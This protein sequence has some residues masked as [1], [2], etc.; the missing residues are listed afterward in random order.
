MAPSQPSTRN[1]LPSS[2]QSSVARK[3]SP[4][5]AGVTWPSSPN[6]LSPRYRSANAPV[7]VLPLSTGGRVPSITQTCGSMP[8]ITPSVG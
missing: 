7:A 8:S 3:A 5:E 2:G 6:V 1:V 4:E